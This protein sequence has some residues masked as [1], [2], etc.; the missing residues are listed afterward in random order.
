[1][2]EMV[3]TFSLFHPRGMDMELEVREL[4]KEKNW[5]N[6]FLSVWGNAPG[7]AFE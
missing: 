2:D 4:E 5:K 7:S 6:L 3:R 1:M